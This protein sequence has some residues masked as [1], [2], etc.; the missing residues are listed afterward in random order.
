MISV[1]VCTRSFCGSNLN[2]F[3]RN[4]FI[5]CCLKYRFRGF[6]L[7]LEPAFILK[8]VV[9]QWV[10]SRKFRWKIG[11]KNRICL[12]LE[13]ALIFKNSSVPVGIIS[14]V[15]LEN[16][17]QEH[18]CSTAYHLSLFR[19]RF[20]FDRYVDMSFGKKAEGEVHTENRPARRNTDT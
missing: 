8:I 15:L 11:T 1:C 20:H 5:I 10:S 17:Y 6:C 14:E 19:T 7:F 13:P 9:F 18:K 16:R 12:F 3:S 4:L 2:I